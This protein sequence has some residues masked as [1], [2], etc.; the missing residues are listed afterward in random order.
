LGAQILRVASDYEQLTHYGIT[1]SEVVDRMT[2]KT[3]IYDSEIVEALGNKEILL[4]NWQVAMV[5]VKS[6]RSGMVLNE[7]VHT[8]DGELLMSKGMELSTALLERIKLAAE[9]KGLIEPFR[10]MYR[11]D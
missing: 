9:N 10:V 7:D 11:P 3:R 5:D 2:R 6:M 4:D 8:K 1:H